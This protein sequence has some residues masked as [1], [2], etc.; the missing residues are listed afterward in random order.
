MERFKYSLVEVARPQI[1]ALI[2][3]RFE[4]RDFAEFQ[5]SFVRNLDK[6]KVLR[7]NQVQAIPQI[8]DCTQNR[9]SFDFAILFSGFFLCPFLCAGTT[10]FPKIKAAA[11]PVVFIGATELLFPTVDY[12]VRHRLVATVIAKDER[13]GNH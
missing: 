4:T 9:W 6:L 7:I 3:C 5:I 1:F 8:D 13:T 2:N 10:V 11:Q 12:F